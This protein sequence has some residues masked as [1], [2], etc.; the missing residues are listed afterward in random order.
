MTLRL[1]LVFPVLA[2]LVPACG[3]CGREAPPLDGAAQ[4][5]VEPPVAAPEA[6][7]AEILIPTPNG[8]WGR[9][10]RGVGGGFGI[11]PA[12][13]GGVLCA[14]GGLDPSLGPEIDGMAPVAGVVTGGD[15]G[16]FGWALA[17]KLVEPRRAKDLLL[18][19]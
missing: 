8:T 9:V 18:D 15:S 19:A 3:S 16:A 5:A 17:A 14:F 10:Q 1:G 12:T 4:G 13:L 2:L 11:L 6:L 7:V